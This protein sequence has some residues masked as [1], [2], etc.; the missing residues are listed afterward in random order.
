MGLP[1]LFPQSAFWPSAGGSAY[2]LYPHYLQAKIKEL[3]NSLNNEFRLIHELCLFV[4]TASQRGD[5]IRATLGCLHAYLS[6][7]PLGYIFES[8]LLDTL[9]KAF[10][11]PPLRNLALQCLAE[12]RHASPGRFRPT[13]YRL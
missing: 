7:I 9:Q 12:V 2:S 13:P 10:P 5:L 11:Q 4:L 8:N 6:W 3:K 1:S